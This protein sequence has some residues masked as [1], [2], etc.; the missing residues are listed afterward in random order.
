MHDVFDGEEHLKQA[1]LAT[2]AAIPWLVSSA[3]GGAKLL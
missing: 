2:V 3:G 1:R